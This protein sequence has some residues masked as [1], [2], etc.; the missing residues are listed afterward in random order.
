MKILALEFSSPQRS[1]SVAH[2]NGFSEV[3]ETGV[4]ANAPLAMIEEA[5]RQANL[6]REQIDCVAVGLG[7]GSYTGIRAAIALAQGWQLARG[8][9][10][11][12]I[13]SAECMAAEAHA[14]RI[15]GRVSVVIDAQREEFYLATYQISEAHSRTA[16]ENIPGAPISS[17]SPPRSGGEGRVEVA[18]RAQREVISAQYREIERLRIVPLEEIQQRS[19]VG[20]TLIGPEVT[21]W[22]PSGKLIFPTS[23]ILAKLARNRTDF[24]SGDKLEPIYLRE[25]K[26]V[27]APPPRI[28]S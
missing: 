19:A 13:S 12:G 4:G 24:I 16:G 23:A 22:I 11:L 3:I 9:K 2:D 27:K 5:L 21:R 17:P 20:N 10:L 28:V 18:L 15:E 7:P 1:V 6:E 14:D 26:F 25:T 8:V